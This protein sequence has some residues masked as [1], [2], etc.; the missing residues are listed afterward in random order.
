MWSALVKNL[1]S[2]TAYSYKLTFADGTVNVSA[3]PYATAAVANGER[4]VVLSSED[5]GSAGDRM[6]EFGKITDATIAENEHPRL[7]HQPEFRNLSRQE[8]QVSGCC[9]IRNEDGERRHLRS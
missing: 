9:G 6:P 2:G 5:M 1:A 4:S 7:L 8:G 3:D